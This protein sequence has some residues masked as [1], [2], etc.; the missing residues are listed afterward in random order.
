MAIRFK[1]VTYTRASI[2][3]GGKYKKFYYHGTIVHAVPGSLGLA[4]FKTLHE[5][6]E[7]KK[8]FWPADRI[9]RVK[10]IGAKG[11]VPQG[12]SIWQAT[13]DKVD[14]F[15]S[16]LRRMKKGARVRQFV[17]DTQHLQATL[18]NGETMTLLIP[19]K[20]TICYQAVEVLT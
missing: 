10:P 18:S 7:A 16:F 5:A 13:D 12:M 15:Y 11:K 1:L 17:S 19:P 8:K 9:I 20:G 2:F 14:G 3:A 6:R 4:C